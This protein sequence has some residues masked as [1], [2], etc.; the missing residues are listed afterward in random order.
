MWEIISDLL[1]DAGRPRKI[2]IMD[3]EFR[4]EP[5]VRTIIPKHLFLLAGGAILVTS[6][7]LVLL[8]AYTPVLYWLPG[9]VDADVRQQARMSALR[10]AALEDSLA[11]Q[12]E[13]ME[14]VRRLIMGDMEVEDGLPPGS[15]PEADGG[16]AQPGPPAD[17]APPEAPSP[18]WGDH[19][20][21][22]IAVDRFPLR[23]STSISPAAATE[24]TGLVSMAL[25]APPPVNGLLTRGFDARSGHLGIDI[26]VEEGSP[27]RS[28]S[29][30][31]VILADW[32][33][34]GGY[35]LAVQHT[36]GYVSVY[37]HNERLLKRR[38]DR[39][40]AQ[41]TIALSGNSGQLTTGPHLHFELWHHGLAQDPRN[42]LIGF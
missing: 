35:T 14:D 15:M 30:G 17:G 37:K 8:V 42:Y 27:V 36:D 2:M 5:S 3:D 16:M 39:V 28:I 1:R 38:G 9:Q 6:I 10:V 29:D 19:E 20:Q 18:D 7:L 13:Y 25:P 22:A 40:S 11:S 23:L 34:D 4:E 21:P 33:H 31:Y 24:A 32:T 26:A 12:N 41:E